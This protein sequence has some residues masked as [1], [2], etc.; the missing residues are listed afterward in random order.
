MLKTLIP[1]ND[2]Y[3]IKPSS[4]ENLI[5]NSVYGWNFYFYFSLKILW[6]KLL[7]STDFLFRCFNLKFSQFLF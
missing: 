6:G 2:D 5:A 1:L 4:W 7:I 3:F